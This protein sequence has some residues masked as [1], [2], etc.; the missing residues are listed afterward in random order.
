MRVERQRTGGRFARTLADSFAWR[1][2]GRI[3]V[4]PQLRPVPARSHLD[5]SRSFVPAGGGLRRTG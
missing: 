2:I 5:T 4:G 3:A 1:G